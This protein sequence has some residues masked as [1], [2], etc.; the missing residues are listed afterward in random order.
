MRQETRAMREMA[1]ADLAGMEASTRG[2]VG[3][4]DADISRARS[5]LNLYRTTVLPQSEATVASALAAYR[6]GGVDFMTLLDARMGTNRYRQEV[7]RLEAE[8]GRAIAE[9]EMLVAVDLLGG[10]Q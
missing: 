4:L 3:E 9:L 10:T 7:I 6:V 1:A 8:L 5:L 2:R